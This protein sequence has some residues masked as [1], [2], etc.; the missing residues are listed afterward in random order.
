MVSYLQVNIL[1]VQQC[2]LLIHKQVVYCT[3]DVNQST[4]Q[5]VSIPMTPS[6]PPQYQVSPLQSD[7]PPH[8]TV[9]LPQQHVPG[10]YAPQ[11]V[12]PSQPGVIYLPQQQ[13]ETGQQVVSLIFYSLYLLAASMIKHWE[14]T[15]P[16]V[17][18]T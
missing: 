14:L 3:V 17:I 2:F 12:Y 4:D 5:A 10:G 13:A 18:R 7:Y 8:Q 1:D 9:F 15:Q 16:C 6:Y 11:P